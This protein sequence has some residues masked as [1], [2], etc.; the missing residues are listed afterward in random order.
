MDLTTVDPDDGAPWDFNAPA[1]REKALRLLRQQKPLFVIGSPMCTRWCTWQKLNDIKRDARIVEEEKKL[2]LIHLEFVA[3]IY[4]EQIDGDR[5]FLHEHPE[6]AGSWSEKCIANLLQNKEVQRVVGDQCQY[7]QE[8]MY[9]TY[10]G[11]PVRKATGFMSNAPR[12]LEKL[13]KRCAGRGGQC[14]R[15]NGGRHVTASGRVAKDA[16][17]YTDALCKAIVHGMVDEMQWRGIWRRGEVGLHAVTDEDSAAQMAE[18]CSGRFR[19]DI[20]GQLLRDDLVREARAKELQYFC[21]KGVWVKRPKSEARQKTGRG[22]ISVRWVDVNKGDDLRPR[23]R[24]RLVAR[25]LKAHDKSGASFFAPT[26]PLEALRS[27]LSLAATTIGNWR[28][29]YDPKSERRTQISLMDI[30][31]AYFNAKLDDDATT[32]VQLP[33]EDEDSMHMCAKLLRHM[34][35]TRAAA[36]GW[37]EEYST[38]LVEALKF[39]QGASSPCVFRH[40]TRELVMTVHG[41]DFTTVGAKEDLD[42]LESQMQDNYELT[43]QPGW[44]GP[45][46]LPRRASESP[47][48]NSRRTLSSLRASTQRSAAPQRARTT[49]QQIAW[50]VNLLQ[51][52]CA[53]GWP[54]QLRPPG[55]H[56]NDCAGTSW[57]CHGWFSITN[58]KRWSRS[59]FTPTQI[60]PDVPEHVKAPAEG[61]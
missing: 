11:Q 41:D 29:C 27:V 47:L 44:P 53:V 5:F 52:R 18:G 14:S 19:D 33:A 22:A 10:H 16:A 17:R 49:L 39:T 61:A 30:S 42:W 28:P 56:S 6:T 43:I 58:G 57:G 8:V 54:N 36:D 50:I 7:A 45:T 4:Q 24:S 31:R 25:Q 35:G 37:Q 15:P 38:F 12:L 20:T 40:P 55:R 9:G 2:A 32:Y 48:T 13:T 60:G 3:Q 59:M 1:K 51:K 23:Y 26:P 21:D 34:Y 46:V